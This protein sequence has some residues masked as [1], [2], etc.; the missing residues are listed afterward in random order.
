AVGSAGSAVLVAQTILLP[1]LLTNN[2]SHL[3]LEGG[4]HTHH[5][6]S[7]DYFSK[8]YLPLINQMGP[9]V[10]TQIDRY[11]FYP[12]G[13]GKFEIFIQPTEKLTKINLLTKGKCLKQNA[14]VIISQLPRDIAIRELKVIATELLLDDE[15][16]I[17]KE[18]LS[19]G[20]GNFVQV[21]YCYSNVTELFTGIGTKGV[22]AEEV[23]I[24]VVKDIQKYLA[25]EVPVGPHLANQ[26]LL[27]MAITGKGSFR[28]MNP[29]IHTRTTIET[30]K[31]FLPIDII[32]KEEDDNCWL[33]TIVS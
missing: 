26:L 19:P 7:F 24:A 10:K 13:G 28:T 1:L 4:T 18:A 3:V 33:I 31:H 14:E 2:K 12:A 32:V 16:F 30:I 17:I 20:P 8:V 6:P 5:A 21:E 22:P 11:G 29:T 15:K 9:K 27:P 25:T 23:A